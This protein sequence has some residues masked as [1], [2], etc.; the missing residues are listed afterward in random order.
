MP[1]PTG[2]KGLIDPYNAEQADKL[3]DRIAAGEGLIAICRDDD[4]P[5]VSSVYKWKNLDIE[6][7]AERLA[8]ARAEG[9]E[10]LAD[11]IRDL[12]DQ[13]KAAKKTKTKALKG[14]KPDGTPEDGDGTV[15]EVETTEGDAIEHRKLQI[16]TRKWLLSKLKPTPYGDK[17]TVV[18][19]IDESA[20]KAI[21]A[22]RRRA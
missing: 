4:M 19:Q 21:L 20:V 15:L 13:Q 6:G 2:I 3:L 9:L 16:D 10:A 5:F 11:Q 1:W 17:Q 8:V 18:H 14:A 22:A 7:F 12:T